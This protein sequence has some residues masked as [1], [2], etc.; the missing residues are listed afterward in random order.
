MSP[1]W[2]PVLLASVGGSLHCAAMCGPF[3]AA[4]T[5]FGPA[6]RAGPAAHVAY[7][8]GR[9]GTYLALGAAGG[10]VG[11]ALDLAGKAAG[12]GRVS[13]LVAGLV[14]VAWGA[15]ALVVRERLVKLGRRAPR[16]E[17]SLLGRALGWLGRFPPVPRAL[18]LGLSTTL[19]PCGWLYAF[20]ATAAGT[21]DVAS[22]LG[23]MFV[24]WLGTLPALVAAGVGLRGLFARLGA[25][26]RTVSA[27]LI[28][29]SGV[30]LLGVR[31]EA[32]KQ[33]VRSA[34]AASTG[35]TLAPCPFHRH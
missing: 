35:A 32:P 21:G 28:A 30:V 25:R 16:R 31:V 33:P 27:V 34:S 15:S 3:M 24:F 11:S 18:L 17:K 10:L 8:L 13:A 20:V 29:V 19:V 14:L 4:V 12:F 2:I 6:G 1:F 23:V 26:A 7:H 9:L 5:G 22:A